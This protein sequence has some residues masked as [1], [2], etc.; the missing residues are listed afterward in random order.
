MHV[1]SLHGFFDCYEE[2]Q[3]DKA[4]AVRCN[5]VK[6]L[7]SLS[8]PVVDAVNIVVHLLDQHVSPQVRDQHHGHKCEACESPKTETYLAILDFEVTHNESL[9]QIEIDEGND[10]PELDAVRAILAIG[11]VLV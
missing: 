5:Q 8:E 4:H 7:E 2:D 3:V 10:Q 1:K 11:G 6:H 9:N